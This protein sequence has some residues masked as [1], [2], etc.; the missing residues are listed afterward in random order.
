M[1]IKSLLIGSAAALV[2][3]T[4]AKAADAVVVA[5]PEP[6]EYVR[7]CDA[8]GAG[9]FYIPGTETCLSISGYVWWQLGAGNYRVH[10]A[11]GVAGDTVGYYDGTT[12]NGWMAN[13]RA[14]V[15]FDA[16]SDTEW[17]TL[18]A[19]MRIQS[20]WNGS[21]PPSTDGPATFDQA[22]IE[23]GGW[24][25]GYTESAWAQTQGGG[26]TNWGSH[27]WGGMYYG[28]QQRLLL[29][30]TFQGGNGFFGTISLE[31]DALNTPPGFNPYIPAPAGGNYIPDVVVKLGVNQGW[32]SVWAMV[33]Y[34]EDFSGSGYP[35][36]VA[37]LPGA[38][39]SGGFGAALGVQI[40]IP[41][42]PGSNLRVI[43]YYAD[44]AHAYNVGSPTSIFGPFATAVPPVV[45]SN[46]YGGAEWSVLASYNHAFSSTL[47]ASVAFQYFNDLY[48][49]GTDVSTGMDAW[50]AELSVV[51]FP[52][53]N[54][55]TRLELHYD[56][57]VST[58]PAIITPTGNP[59]GT[60]SG[61]LRFTRYF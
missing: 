41:N 9:F 44:G 22:F 32:G 13:V 49:V 28:Y 59:D 27:S 25:M 4:G 30:Y 38:P 33:G 54:F 18:R 16:R 3:A 7:V 50:G 36:T 31:D 39:N 56:D 23:L 1:K 45:P 29:A 26:A 60:F 2:A 52:V 5:E 8:Y 42:M 37:F 10:S 14:R 21:G 35:A 17:G 55:E 6:V 40:N 53:E 15:N 61:F 43:G 11:P 48:F 12:A 19:F 58:H 34:D 57:I 20:T 24:R 51:W 46:I 47:S